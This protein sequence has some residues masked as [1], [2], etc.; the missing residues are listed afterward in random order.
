MNSPDPPPSCGG[1]LQD[2]HPHNGTK[3]ESKMNKMAAVAGLAI[4]L[5]LVSGDTAVECRD[6]FAE[7]DS[8]PRDGTSR[9]R[10]ADYADKEVSK[11]VFQIPTG[12]HLFLSAIAGLGVVALRGRTR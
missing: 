11:D 9:I 2:E 4:F 7:L 1:T 12:V 5:T 6:G 10:Q 3:K 8:D